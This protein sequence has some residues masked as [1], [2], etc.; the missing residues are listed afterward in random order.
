M[1]LDLVEFEKKFSPKTKLLFLN[2]PNNP[3]GKVFSEAE[4]LGIAE[5]VKRHPN[6]VV[7]SDEVYEWLVYK[8]NKMIRF[9][10]DAYIEVPSLSYLFMTFSYFSHSPRN[11]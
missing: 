11:V 3:V 8:P 7:V 4:L 2:N 5:V 9:G 6:V 1:K 10:I